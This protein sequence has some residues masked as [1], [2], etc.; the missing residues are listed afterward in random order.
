MPRVQVAD[1]FALAVDAYCR[2]LGEPDPI[3][4]PLHDAAAALERR[5][6]E[7]ARAVAEARVT[8]ATLRVA[9]AAVRE[10]QRELAELK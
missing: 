1:G 3:A 5:I 10:A 8:E 7:A 2:G 4:D 9:L 6:A